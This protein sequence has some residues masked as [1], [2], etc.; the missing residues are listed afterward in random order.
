MNL[1]GSITHKMI[2]L[3]DENKE[4]REQIKW[5][6][7]SLDRV[8]K[9]YEHERDENQEFKQIHNEVKLGIQKSIQEFRTDT[10]CDHQWTKSC[11]DHFV[12]VKCP[13]TKTREI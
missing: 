8:T 13:E 6:I 5:L 2:A 10:E 9:L 11:A 7:K 1:E 12:C 4:L 3:K